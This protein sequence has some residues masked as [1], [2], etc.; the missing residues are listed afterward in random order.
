LHKYCT[1]TYGIFTRIWSNN[2]TGSQDRMW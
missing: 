1:P 2:A